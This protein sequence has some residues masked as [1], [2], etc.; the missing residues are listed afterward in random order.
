MTGLTF[1]TGPDSD[2]DGPI[3]IMTQFEPDQNEPI[4]RVLD[5]HDQNLGPD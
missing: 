5:R 1:V 3:D 2:V 4:D